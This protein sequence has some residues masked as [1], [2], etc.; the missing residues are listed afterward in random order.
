MLLSLTQ[1][2]LKAGFLQLT[3][4]NDGKLLLLLLLQKSIWLWLWNICFTF[5]FEKWHGW[6]LLYGFF[7][8]LYEFFGGL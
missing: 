3:V 6:Y 8:S 5:F 4:L 7:C 1:C 2:F